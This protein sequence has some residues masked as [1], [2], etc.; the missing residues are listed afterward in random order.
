MQEEKF[1]GVIVLLL[2]Y[3]GW[4]CGLMSTSEEDLLDGFGQ[5]SDHGLER[6]IQESGT[7]EIL[8]QNGSET[9]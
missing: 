2:C 6:W 9:L 4:G 5:L 1:V 3:C 7:L 8:V